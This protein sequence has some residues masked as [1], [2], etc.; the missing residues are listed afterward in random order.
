MNIDHLISKKDLLAVMGISYGQLYRWKRQRLI[1]E[2][3]F[4]KQSAYTGQETFFPREQILSRIQS[5]LELKDKYSLD[6]LARLLSPQAPGTEFYREELTTFAEIDQKILGGLPADKKYTYPELGFLSALSSLPL[7][8]EELALLVQKGFAYA[9]IREAKGCVVFSAGGKTCLV[10]TDSAGALNFDKDV[11]VL[12]VFSLDE[13]TAK[14]K[15]KY[16]NEKRQ[17]GSQG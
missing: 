16:E 10:F 9:G 12:G 6:E 7:S 13:E 2:E 17:K 1:P 5:I 11:Q 14:L 15:M 8:G 3:W 4:L